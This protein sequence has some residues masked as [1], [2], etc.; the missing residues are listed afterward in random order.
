MDYE[1]TTFL[2]FF[3]EKVVVDY[4]L[5]AFLGF[6]FEKVVVDQTLVELP[7]V[8]QVGVA[9]HWGETFA[10]ISIFQTTQNYFIFLDNKNLVGFFASRIS[11]VDE[12]VKQ[13]HELPCKIKGSCHVRD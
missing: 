3:F 10:R 13:A 8:D 1:L 4:E 7:L 2:G 9:P 11:P 5:P 6:F 12:K